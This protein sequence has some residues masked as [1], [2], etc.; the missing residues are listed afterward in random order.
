[1]EGT[2]PAIDIFKRAEEI[3]NGDVPFIRKA[4][5][6]QKPPAVFPLHPTGRHTSLSL[7]AR[8]ESGGV[9]GTPVS[10]MEGGEGK[11]GAVGTA[12]GL[13]RLQCLPYEL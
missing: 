1:M 10:T 13:T 8:R 2:V 3:P 12:M 4:K 7:L 6:F 5:L 11:W 9:A